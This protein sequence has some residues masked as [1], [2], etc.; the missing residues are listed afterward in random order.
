MAR[1]GKSSV[2]VQLFPFL[3]VLVCM[4]GSLIFLLLVTTRQL[5]DQA[6]AR[7][8]QRHREERADRPWLPL[9]SRDDVATDRPA[10][11]PAQVPQR[12]PSVVDA[13]QIELAP[14][15][16]AV[17]VPMPTAAEPRRL[18]MFQGW[19]AADAAPTV[20]VPSPQPEAEPLPQPAGPSLEE[21]RA[22]WE[23][24][25]AALAEQRHSRQEAVDRQE[26]LRAAAQRRV[27]DLETALRD[28]Q[29]KQQELQR[30]WKT[31]RVSATPLDRQRR[32]L[33]QQITQLRQQL[34]QASASNEADTGKFRVVP[35][36]GK[37]G[38]ARRP[39]MIECTAHGFVF[40]PEGIA[41]TPDDLEGFTPRYNPLLA[42][43]K[44]LVEYWLLHDH[45]H[46]AK[47]QRQEPYVLLIVRP[48][49]TLAYYISMKLLST[50]Q[51]PF[52]YELV[53]E[54]TELA[55]PPVDDHA[56]AACQAAIAQLLQERAGIL[57]S[58][59]GSGGTGGANGAGLP[60]GVNGSNGFR[61]GGPQGNVF[62]DG[63]PA[64]PGMGGRAM[65]RG[66]QS[67][68]LAFE[69]GGAVTADGEAAA[70]GMDM[71]GLSDFNQPADSL[72]SAHSNG[73]D[74]EAAPAATKGAFDLSDLEPG[75]NEVGSRSWEKIDQFRGREFRPSDGDS[76]S[77]S[78]EAKSSS[79]QA[80]SLPSSP[81]GASSSPSS[82]AAGRERPLT[83]VTRLGD[84]AV[85][86]ARTAEAPSQTGPAVGPEDQGV[87]A[88]EPSSDGAKATSPGAG[89]G[90]PRF[91]S[92]PKSG[93][94]RSD[95][96]IPY[97]QL[98]RRRWGLS[99]P[100]ATIG[101][102]KVALIWVGPDRIVVGDVSEVTVIPGASRSEIFDQVLV[103]VDELAVSWGQPQSGFYWVPRLKFVISPGGNQL[104]QR[105]EP[106]VSRTGLPCE[107]SD[108]LDP[109]APPRQ[110]SPQEEPR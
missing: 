56:R 75:E 99:E 12:L 41:V 58:T 37:S 92:R 9:L 79:A 52:G 21:L 16:V 27:Q 7:A 102:E 101:V 70:D 76:S 51:I 49:G 17:P 72:G 42:G 35:F 108:T 22:E 19:T 100:H 105:I 60:A 14:E 83:R 81:P 48:S 40:V 57:A 34:K 30:Q 91:L 45:Q 36:D 106:L 55:W 8:E 74:G 95:R 2:T 1:R 82:S 64:L 78:T 29:A 47:E 10:K 98:Y 32:E 65:G 26:R 109:V 43:T 23:S 84:P 31:T 69:A 96:E 107:R 46:V 77:S 6:V 38:T 39:I 62:R 11:M 15:P 53:S 3:A 85:P 24:R 86:A 54:E 28:S 71:S 66:Q 103:A 68:S 4:M 44:A 90:Q 50:L 89:G 104:Y 94:A 80:K 18:E 13:V 93:S 59:N 88:T 33:E 25:V 97:E 73:Q 61:A 5:R 87:A 63:E 67:P 20:P 110:Q